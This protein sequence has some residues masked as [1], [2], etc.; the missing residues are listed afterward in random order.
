ML[1]FHLYFSCRVHYLNVVYS[2]FFH[3][4]INRFHFRLFQCL[5]ELSTCNLSEQCMQTYGADQVH[6]GTTVST[7][8]VYL[9]I[10]THHQCWPTLNKF[11]RENPGQRAFTTD[12]LIS[13]LCNNFYDE[14]AKLRKDRKKLAR[15]DSQT[16]QL[17]MEQSEFLDGSFG[18]FWEFLEL[19]VMP[20]IAAKKHVKT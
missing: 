15:S 4:Q 9:A 1:F 18:R 6:R 10:L 2:Y 19:Y 14:T 5:L 7:Q 17:V 3:F 13:E 11:L 16:V 8:L 12:D 20:R